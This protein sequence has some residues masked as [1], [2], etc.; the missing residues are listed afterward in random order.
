MGEERE[1]ERERGTRQHSKA[2]ESSPLR[3]QLPAQDT[4]LSC[5]EQGRKRAY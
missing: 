3:T 2:E 1:R 4:R 5:A